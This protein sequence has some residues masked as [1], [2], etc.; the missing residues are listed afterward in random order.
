MYTHVLF[1]LDGT[2][3]DSSLGI[4][5]CAQ[6][7]L[8]HFGIEV[9]DLKELN[10]FIGPPLRETFP[11]FGIPEDKVEE[12]ISIFRSRYTTVG[13]FENV[14]YEGIKEL[15]ETLNQHHVHCYVATSKLENTA[16]E[17]LDKF[18]LSKYFDCIAGASTDSSR[19]SK[20]QV[21]R[22]LFKKVEDIKD[23]VMVGDTIF[24]IEGA[25][26][27]GV[28]SIGVSWGFGDITKMKEVGATYIVDS[29]KHLQDVILGLC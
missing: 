28:D 18:D 6:L 27:T 22:Y 12:A 23:A 2:L 24:D 19:D 13:K 21:I 5:K 25:K 20:E 26:K 16:K 15:L 11:K 29:C 8:H 9:E 1:D 14:P 4:T 10:V 17:I 7:A 3:T